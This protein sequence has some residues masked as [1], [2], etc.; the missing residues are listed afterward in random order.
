MDG[1]ISEQSL[2][3]SIG[4]LFGSDQLYL[5]N[6]IEDEFDHIFLWEYA[7][8]DKVCWNSKRIFVIAVKEVFVINEIFCEL[9][10]HLGERIYRSHTEVISDVN[11]KSLHQLQNDGSFVSFL[12]IL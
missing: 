3:I 11:K 4:N 1:A 5:G 12:S 7:S 2:K 8:K 9:C 6:K 10:K